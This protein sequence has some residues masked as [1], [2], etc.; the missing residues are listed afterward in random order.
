ARSDYLKKKVLVEVAGEGVV[1]AKKNF[2][3]YLDLEAVYQH[4]DQHPDTRFMIN[5]SY[6]AGLT[7][8]VPIFEGGLR[9]AE[10]SEARSI[11]REAELETLSLKRDMETEIRQAAAQYETL[12]SVIEFYKKQAEFAE[13]NYTMVFKQ[14]GY[15]LARNID[16]IDADLT[17]VTAQREL[18]NAAYDRELAAIELKDR[19]GL[20]LKEVRTDIKR[21]VER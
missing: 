10:L 21:S 6:Y 15:G 9:K 20:L 19:V 2:L 3:P 13:E 5:D 8:T 17:L 11:Q 18:A 12:A 1:Y 7:L 16:V 14:F 4:K